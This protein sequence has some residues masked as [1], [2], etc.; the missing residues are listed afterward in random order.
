MAKS[1]DNGPID[2][3]RDIGDI[4]LNSKQD[5]S[6]VSLRK[7]TSSEGQYQVVQRQ[8]DDKGEVLGKTG[9]MLNKSKSFLSVDHYTMTGDFGPIIHDRLTINPESGAIFPG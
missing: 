3:R 9:L 8:L 1:G 7:F 4:W 5:D 6:S 2:T